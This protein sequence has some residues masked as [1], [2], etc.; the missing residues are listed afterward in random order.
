[1]PAISADIPKMTWNTVIKIGILT[2][3]DMINWKLLIKEKAIRIIKAMIVRA[4]ASL[5]IS[6]CLNKTLLFAYKTPIKSIIKPVI[7]KIK[8]KSA[9]GPALVPR[10]TMLSSIHRTIMWHD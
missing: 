3:W 8:A 4:T 1:M 10:N 5:A 7:D 2:K 6:K 9:D